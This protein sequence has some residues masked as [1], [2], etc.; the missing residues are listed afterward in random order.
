MNIKKKLTIALVVA[1]AVPLI[2]FTI[3]SLNNSIKSATQSAMTDNLQRSELAQEK[4][5]KFVDKNLNGVKL[6]ATNPIVRSYDAQATKPVLIDAAKVYKDLAPIV[7]TG[8]NAMQ[9]VKSDSA[10]L[11][12]VADRNFF[13]D[14]ISGKEEV[15]SEVLVSK[16]NGHLIS[17]LA[18][19]VKDAA[20]GK[21]TGVIQGSIE[22][23]ILTDIVKSLSKENVNVYVLDRDGKLLAHPTKDLQKAEDRV[24]LTKFDFVKQALSGK[25][26]S[27]M[28]EIDGTKM[29]VSYTKNQKSG[30]IICSEIPYKAAI[31]E[32]VKEAI[33]T[34]VTGLII[35][36]FT[37]ALA[38]W[39]AGIATKPIYA[40]V[41]AADHIAN[42]N[43]AVEEIQIKSKDELGT[44]AKSFNAMV[45]NL[46]KLIRQ[47][48]SNAETV[49][50]ASQQLNASADQSAQASNQVAVSI[51][52]VANG[53]EKQRMAVE[54][55]SKVVA[56]MSDNIGH[57]TVSVRAVSEQS[58]QS[59]ST[60]REGGKAVQEAVEQMIELENTVNESA[61][62]VTHLGERSKEIGQ[63]VNTISGIAG[64]TNLLALNAAIEAARA[65]EQG[66]G[67][68]VVAEEV[69]KLAEQSQ[70]AAKQIE[71]LIREIQGETEKAV[72]AMDV[73]TVKTKEATG[74][75]NQAGKAFQEIV[76]RVA[77]LSKQ[78][79][80]ITVAVGQLDG[81]SQEIVSSVKEIDSLT[82][83][84][85]D[86]AQNVSA[87]TQEQAASMHEIS[88]SSN[89]LTK[90]AVELQAEITKFR[91]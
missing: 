87:A 17:V 79:Q 23:S 24:D 36:L 37:G 15:V 83:S 30:W 28:V 22:L 90:M 62:V 48:Q 69:R 8:A 63:I 65:G 4:I 78:I 76:E 88:D 1:S 33:Y 26:G 67:F 53:A 16:D 44:L 85:T 25:S 12:N 68:A 38:F 52:E 6:L 81:G 61:K 18:A 14:A 72:Q 91:T 55:T 51:T 84:V 73:G 56:N 57:A 58:A 77:D 20:S 7:V 54:N 47:V 89:A 46:R 11:A 50:A 31:A 49:A 32:S 19:P 39:L 13:K 3:I 34:S 2:I 21:V 29:M 43:L 41:Q 80:E 82:H 45:E 86:E 27:D 66:R 64:Q 9:V 35:L 40:I 59:A 74:V 70:I 10:P 60:A 71:D 75:V 42:G 5:D